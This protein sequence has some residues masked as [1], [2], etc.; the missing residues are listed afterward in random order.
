[1]NPALDLLLHQATNGPTSLLVILGM[2][3]LLMSY[4][5]A[6]FLTEILTQKM[7]VRTPIFITISLIFFLGIWASIAFYGYNANQE[8]L[9]VTNNQNMKLVGVTQY[10][11]GKLTAWAVVPPVVEIQEKEVMG[12]KTLVTTILEP[13]QKV[14]LSNACI[15]FLSQDNKGIAQWAQQTRVATK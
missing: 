13:K 4:G 2:I 6:T 5:L 1:M 8:I 11:N 15:E 12:Q 9:K 10:P 3:S 7:G 14:F